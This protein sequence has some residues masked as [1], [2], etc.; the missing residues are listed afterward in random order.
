MV[1]N[2]TTGSG[3]TTVSIAL[4]DSVRSLVAEYLMETYQT[5]QEFPRQ[6]GEPTFDDTFVIL[7][8]FLDW[9]R[10]RNAPPAITVRKPE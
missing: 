7:N 10:D 5:Y 1:S 8:C 2:S 4:P 3:G 6:D 9:E